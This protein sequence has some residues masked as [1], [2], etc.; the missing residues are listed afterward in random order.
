MYTYSVTNHDVFPTSGAATVDRSVV[1][2]REGDRV[3]GT[4]ALLDNNVTASL[5]MMVRE[6][7]MSSSS[8]VCIASEDERDELQDSASSD[9]VRLENTY[10]FAARENLSYSM[11]NMYHESFN[12]NWGVSAPADYA[13]MSDNNNNNSEDTR[14]HT[15]A[16]GATW[17]A[18]AE[19]ENSRNHD[20]EGQYFLFGDGHVNFENDPFV[21]HGDENVFAITANGSPAPPTLSNRAGDVV[22]DESLVATDSALLP[23]SGNRG[24]SVSGQ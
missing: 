23:L 1:G 19:F 17:D 2:F 10:D 22:N 15:L 8:F 20:T 7:S 4:G 9:A 18:A 13:L 24:V 3:A 12:S 5:W 14:R 11:I 21:G 16:K 6:G